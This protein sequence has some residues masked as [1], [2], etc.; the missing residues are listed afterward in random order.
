MLSLMSSLT[1]DRRSAHRHNLKIPVRYRVGLR[2]GSEHVSE[3]A[4]LSE[5]GISFTTDQ[6]LSVG[7]IVELWLE[8]PEEINGASLSRWLCTG[9]VVR[10]DV[11]EP[12]SGRRRIGVQFDCHEV[13]NP[14]QKLRHPGALEADRVQA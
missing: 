2:S 1:R 8:M 10:I 12:S 14:A 7:A 5:L 4:N 13:L 11:N 3:S 6:E 9:H